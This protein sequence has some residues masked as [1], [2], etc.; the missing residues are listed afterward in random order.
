MGASAD[1]S[2]IRVGQKENKRAHLQG[3]EEVNHATL[4]QEWVCQDQVCLSLRSQWMGGRKLR[5]KAG[6][7]LSWM[8]PGLCHNVS[9]G[10]QE[11]W[12]FAKRR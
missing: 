3:A 1:E 10:W 12:V 6:S 7:S 4:R 8:C 2:T 9:S 5:W 11:I